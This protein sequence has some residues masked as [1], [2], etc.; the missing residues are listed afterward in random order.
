MNLKKQPFF[1]IA[2]FKIIF[3]VTK[4]QITNYFMVGLWTEP[5]EIV[6]PPKT[7]SYGCRLKVLAPEFLLNQEVAT[8]INSL[9]QLK[10]T[11]LNLDKFNLHNFN[12]IVKQ[13]ETEIIKLKPSKQIQDNKL[14]LSQLLYKKN[15]SISALEVS[16]Q[17]FWTNRQINRYLNKYLGVS[18][19]KYLNIQ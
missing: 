5:K 7:S 3:Y 13:W 1:Q 19:K 18:L 15:G 11:F 10:L 2:F 4:G 12:S 17:V 14:R 8:I 6:I 16:K 9:K